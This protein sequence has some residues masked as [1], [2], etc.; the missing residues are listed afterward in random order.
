MAY[1]KERLESLI[2]EELSKILLKEFEFDALV[3]ITGVESD[4]E[5]KTAK[6]KFSLIPSEK[7]PDILKY[8]GKNRNQIQYLLMKKIR[9][10]TLPQIRFEIDYGPEE[11]GKIEKLLIES[12]KKN[13]KRAR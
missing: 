11:A 13:K 8:L 3:T 5:Y 4:K 7:A 1:K 6:V 10:N 12:K 9:I 2:R